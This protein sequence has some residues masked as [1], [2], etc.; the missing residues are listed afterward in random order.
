MQ[1]A[2]VA[3][4]VLTTAGQLLAQSEPADPWLTDYER[5]GFVKTPRYAETVAYCQRLASHSPWVRYTLFGMSPQGRE[6]P[7][8]ILSRDR[9]FT[10]AAARRTGKAI[11]LIQSGIHAGEIDGKDASLM[12][13]RE[14]AITKQQQRL[15]DHAILLFV[16]I[17]NVD[18]HERVSPYNRINQNGPEEMGWRATAQNLNL[19]RDYMKADAPEMRAMLRLFTS[20]L[21]D[22]YVDCHVTDGMDFQYDVTYT[23]ETGPNI[24]T[25]VGRWLNDVFLPYV[26]PKVEAAGHKIFYYVSPREDHDITKGINLTATTP[27]FSTG[28]AALQNRPALLIET[29]MLKPYRTRVE[30]THDLLKAVIELVNREAGSLRTA[31]TGADHA[32][33]AGGDGS[34]QILPL[35]FGLGP[36]SQPHTFL[37]V[38]TRLEPGELS[39]ALCPVYSSR[40]QEFTVPVFDE[41]TVTDS[42]PIPFAYLIPPEWAAVQE[43]LQVH[44]I[45]LARLAE[46]ATLEVESCTFDNVNFSERPYEGRQGVSFSTRPLREM[47]TYPRGTLVVRT[48]Q[49]AAKVAVNLLEP[50]GPDALVRWGFFNAIF[51]EKEY[52]ETYVMEK[53]GKRFLAD[54]PALKQEFEKKIKDDPAFAANP[55][56]RINWLYLRSPWADPWLNK[57]PI[58]RLPKPVAL[59]TAK[60]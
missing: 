41:I 37:G 29:H 17:F 18:G 16:P 33:I 14:L 51:E 13:I 30:A 7:L 53:V 60:L 2:R 32:T 8:V 9:A 34:G 48:D 44:G 11:I 24:D 22:L 6:L 54:N 35:K 45:V 1:S 47:R 58:A 56:A 49:R 50:G 5:S 27:R 12:L 15:L 57:Y 38:E 39:G 21:P 28:Y 23:V 42:V 40:P 36:R 55:R 59:R 52:S 19:N 3:F 25:R 20:W 4:L 43:V 46:S 10:P 31:V 26:L